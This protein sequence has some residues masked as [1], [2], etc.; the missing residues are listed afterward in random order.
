MF[1]EFERAMIVERGSA[2]LKRAK[3]DGIKLGCGKRKDGSRSLDKERW[4]RKPQKGLTQL[5]KPRA[6]AVMRL[7]VFAAIFPAPSSVS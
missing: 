7:S 5:S 2:G 3:R 4:C 1:A 6:R